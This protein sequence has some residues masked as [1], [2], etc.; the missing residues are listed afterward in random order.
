MNASLQV[1]RRG[2]SLAAWQ[3]SPVYSREFP[4]DPAPASDPQNYCYVNGF[5]DV[6]DLPCRVATWREVAARQ[7]EL[8]TDWPVEALYLPGPNR[9][10]EFSQFR[11]T[12]TRL[13]R[14][15]RTWLTTENDRYVS[16]RLSTRGGVHIWVDGALAARFEPYTRNST[17]E[18]VVHL[19]LRAAGSEVVVVSEDM[20]ERDTN[21]FFELSQL[22][23]TPVVVH[24]PGAAANV[25]SLTLAR[26]AT[27]VRCEGEFVLDGVIRLAFDT[28]AVEPVAISARI[29]STSHDRSFELHR[30]VTLAPRETTVDLCAASD[31]PEGYCVIALELASGT[32]RVTRTIGCP[33]VRSILPRQLDGDIAQRKRHVLDNLA[34]VGEMRMGTALAMLAT[35]RPPDDRF[36]EILERTLDV[37]EN[38]HDCS[39]FVLVPLLWACERYGDLF[40]ADLLDRSRAAI[41][42][43][44][45]WVDE[46][47]N[48]VMWFWS[49]NHALCFHVSQLLAG[50]LFHDAVFSASGRTGA[51]QHALASERLGL[52]FDAVEEDG[53]AEWNSAAYYPVDFVGLL[54]LAELAPAELATR[55]KAAC[56]RIFTM[57]A[58]HTSGGVPAGSM[59]RAYD[60][61]LRAGP[62]TEL[63]PFATLAWGRGWLNR[64][65]A[66]LPEFADSGYEPPAGLEAL[67]WPA[68]GR[69]ITARYRQG[70]GE[71]ARLHLFK[72]AALQLSTNSAARAGGYGHQQHVVD[73]LFS[74]HPFA[75]S[76][77][78]HPGE[79]DP[80]GTQ[81]PSY[82]AGNG[83]LPRA[84]QRDN[85]SLILFDL[86]ESPRLDFTHLYVA[87]DVIHVEHMGSRLILKSGEGLAAILAT[88]D[89]VPVTTGPAAGREWRAHGRRHGWAVIACDHGDQ[90]RFRA[91]IAETEL[92]L[93]E[94]DLVLAGASMRLNWTSG[95]AGAEGETW[96]STPAISVSRTR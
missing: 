21:W 86:G 4:G 40:P 79:D 7:R 53:L 51:E 3:L 63:A 23:D 43:Y 69:T 13:E 48:D 31:V 41:L 58:L 73:L 15:C 91:E 39:D 20:A 94:G 84:A 19:P 83:V 24:L 29:G 1:L 42:G 8:K 28:P 46:P 95:L 72:T 96:S 35:G 64:G 2:D 12:P 90:A 70:F 44:R 32:S 22:D 78:N 11:H 5:V 65:V 85:A 34:T 18:T 68:Q 62:L 80:W 88:V 89:L 38:R 77:I 71:A 56:D 87:A 33:V 82:W 50:S 36:R 47:G 16:Y 14:W 66:S 59:G 67:A 49:E 30:T 6:G 45:Y 55:A 61:E 57:L 26:L 92:R 54:A 60:K 17:E 81:R 93:S 76:W 10:V 9:R 25:E 75:R 27:E 37:I 74:A 52:W